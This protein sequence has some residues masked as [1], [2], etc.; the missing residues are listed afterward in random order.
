MYNYTAV[1]RLG[2]Y[3]TKKLTLKFEQVVSYD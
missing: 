1:H 3:V 2:Q